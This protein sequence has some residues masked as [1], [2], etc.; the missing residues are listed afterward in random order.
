MGTTGDPKLTF[1]DGDVDLGPGNQ[2]TGL[3][4]VTGNVTM[5]GNTSF[6]GVI[7][8]LGGGTVNRNGGGNGTISGGIIVAKFDS[9][10]DFQAPTFTTNGGGNSTIQYDSNSVRDATTTVPGYQVLGV[11]EK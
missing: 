8:V 10:G 3:L 11:V 6:D 9:T 7:L 4:V 1:V 2:G 5:H